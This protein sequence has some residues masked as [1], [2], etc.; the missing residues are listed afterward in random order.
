MAGKGKVV[1][2][3]GAAVLP[4]DDMLDVKSEVGILVLMDLDNIRSD[5]PPAEPPACVWPRRSCR[6]VVSED[7]AR[8]GL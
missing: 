7:P 3:I 6:T 8:F 4:R 2:F 1:E 5:S